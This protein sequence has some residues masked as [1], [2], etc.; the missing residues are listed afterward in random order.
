MYIL[1]TKKIVICTLTGVLRGVL[2]L[3]VKIFC[4]YFGHIYIF[5]EYYSYFIMLGIEIYLIWVTDLIFG[6]QKKLK[7]FDC[8][9]ISERYLA[10]FYRS[11]YIS[12]ERAPVNVRTILNV[13]MRSTK[14]IL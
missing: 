10:M 12:R 9:L 2:N 4:A 5:S 14:H 11:F 8:C 13:W 1:Q 6:V 3:P 7:H